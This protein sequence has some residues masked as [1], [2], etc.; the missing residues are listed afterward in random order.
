MC[1]GR[2]WIILICLR[3]LPSSSN[4]GL[5]SILLPFRHSGFVPVILGTECFIVQIILQ[6]EEALTVATVKS[7]TTTYSTVQLLLASYY[8]YSSLA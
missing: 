1:R 8:E 6:A 3:S 4:R 5:A 7:E 2:V